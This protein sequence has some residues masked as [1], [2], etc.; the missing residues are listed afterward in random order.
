MCLIS[1]ALK[2]VSRIENENKRKIYATTKNI[3][4]FEKIYFW[5]GIKSNQERR[6]IENN[7]VCPHA[8]WVLRWP[9]QLIEVLLKTV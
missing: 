1:I 9:S 2:N 3:L 8:N 4:H 5:E 7:V 6:K